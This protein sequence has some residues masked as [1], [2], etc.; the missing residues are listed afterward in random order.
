MADCVGEFEWFC[1]V[2]W[3]V[4]DGRK[5]TFLI[6]E[7]LGAAV[8]TSAKAARWFF[9]LLTI[10]RKF[11]LVVHWTSQ[12]VATVPKTATRETLRKVIGMCDMDTDVARMARTL[13]VRPDQLEGLKPLQFFVTEYPAPARL[14]TLKYH[15]PAG[16]RKKTNLF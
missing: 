12:S 15:N 16:K 10:C 9:N 11:G 4:L 1:S 3:R 2:V 6:V 14:V 7:E 8:D 13:R 5:R